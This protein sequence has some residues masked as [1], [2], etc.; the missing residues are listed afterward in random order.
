MRDLTDKDI[1]EFGVDE[2]GGVLVTR[3]VAGL[4][5]AEAG[6]LVGDVVTRFNGKAVGYRH[7]WRQL[8]QA[9]LVTP[10]GTSVPVEIVRGGDRQ[11]L[12]V[13]V[14]KRPKRT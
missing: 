10:P 3:V 2:T 8:R 12:D 1:A 14:T 7:A 5:A 9:I 6:I 13:T 4:P 11:T